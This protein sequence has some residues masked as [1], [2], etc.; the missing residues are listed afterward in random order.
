[1]KRDNRCNEVRVGDEVTIKAQGLTITGKVLSADW[2]GYEDGW[3]IE[4]QSKKGYHYWK[5]NYDGGKL[6]AI[7]GQE[8]IKAESF[9]NYARFE[10]VIADTNK[11]EYEEA[12]WDDHT[13]AGYI[14]WK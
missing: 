10:R 8:V 6:I 3:Y 7:N 13:M 4:L 12:Y 5:Q 11:D 1:M 2:W 14:I 9:E